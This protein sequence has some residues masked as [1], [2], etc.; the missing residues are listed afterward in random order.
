[1]A[2][3]DEVVQDGLSGH[4]SVDPVVPGLE[5]GSEVVQQNVHVRRVVAA[6]LLT[7]VN[8]LTALKPRTTDPG[9]LGPPDRTLREGSASHLEELEVVL[10]F[11]DQV[12][13]G[14]V[15]PLPVPVRKPSIES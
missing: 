4:V 15:H 5:V 11:F 2:H 6:A 8:T 13:H 12:S 3:L 10:R 1:M 14:E 7:A 9:Q